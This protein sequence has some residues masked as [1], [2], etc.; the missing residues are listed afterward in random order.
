[1]QMQTMRR[2]APR[3]V[4]PRAGPAASRQG[5]ASETPAARR[6]VLRGG[7]LQIGNPWQKNVIP[8]LRLTVFLITNSVFPIGSHAFSDS[9]IWIVLEHAHGYSHWMGFI[10]NSS[11]SALE[12]PT[13][14]SSPQSHPRMTV[15]N[16]GDRQAFSRGQL[17]AISAESS[18]I[19]NASHLLGFGF[20]KQTQQVFRG[21]LSDNSAHFA[22][23]QLV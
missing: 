10:R 23:L 11:V 6:K 5:R 20:V 8:I 21:R 14:T 15:A 9:L 19:R 13:S 7:S 16:P 22:H 17:P 2:G 12:M 1:M 18:S 3:A 4:Q